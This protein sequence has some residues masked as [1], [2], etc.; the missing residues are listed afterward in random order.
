MT[1]VD[2]NWRDARRRRY[3]WGHSAEWVAAVWLLL[4]GYRLIARRVKTPMGEI[5]LIAVRGGRIAFV[6][7]K[8]RRSRD[9]G[10]AALRPMQGRRMR[11]AADYWLARRPHYRQ[12][13]RGFDAVLVLE[14]RWPCHLENRM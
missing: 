13:T 11:L 4:H 10:E 12:H 7:V 9:E 1:D 8:A 2:S 6:E 3:L 14:G 5:D